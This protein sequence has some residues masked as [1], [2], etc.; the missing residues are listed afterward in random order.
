[1]KAL[2]RNYS[3]LLIAAFFAFLLSTNVFGQETKIKEKDLPPAVSK[4]FQT[5]YPSA[6][7][8]GTAKEVEKGVTYFEVE[9][10]DGKIRRDLLYTETGKVAEI[11]E[12]L[13]AESIPSFVK[14]SIEKKFKDVEYKKGEKNVR[15]STTKYEVVIEASEVKYEV[16]CDAKGKIIKSTKLKKEENDEKD[17]D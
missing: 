5:G 14:S 8:V 11:E 4:A 12:A 16:V 1:M 15:N 10:R 2:T 3:L 6:K 7:I 9:S 17:N 13:S